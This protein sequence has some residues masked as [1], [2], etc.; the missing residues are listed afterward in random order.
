MLSYFSQEKELKNNQFTTYIF[1]PK[2]GVDLPVTIKA[3]TKIEIQVNPKTGLFKEQSF[4]SYNAFGN[5][6]KTKIS[7]ANYDFSNTIQI[8]SLEYFI[9]QNENKQ[10]ELTPSF[11]S[12][13]L[14]NNLNKIVN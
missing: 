2:K 8:P 7:F 9:T 1:V 11:S 10:L 14:K 12:Y 3:F 13:T 4:Y 5:L 6:V